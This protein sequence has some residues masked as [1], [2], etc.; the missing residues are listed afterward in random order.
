MGAINRLFW[1]VGVIA[2]LAI[3]LAF[4]IFIGLYVISLLVVPITWLWSVL[5]GKSYHYVIDQSAILYRINRFG[6]WA[7]FLTICL[8]ISY[9]I[10]WS[11]F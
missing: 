2:L 11:N 9:V 4:N 7:W 5:T 6:Q 3:F 10:F 8:V 1:A